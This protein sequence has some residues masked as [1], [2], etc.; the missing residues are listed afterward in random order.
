MSFFQRPMS[1]YPICVFNIARAWEITQ[2]CWLPFYVIQCLDKGTR[3]SATHV[4]QGHRHHYKARR[5][6]FLAVSVKPINMKKRAPPR[7]NHARKRRDPTSRFSQ[8]IGSQFL[9]CWVKPVFFTCHNTKENHLLQ[10][11][12]AEERKTIARAAFCGHL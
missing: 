10:F 4:L 12:I 3:S 6:A 5:T 1:I 2:D 9:L 8:F 11:N 7:T